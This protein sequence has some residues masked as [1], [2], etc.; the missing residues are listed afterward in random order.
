M[1][2]KKKKKKDGKKERK[3][4]KKRKEK[5]KKKKKETQRSRSKV[6]RELTFGSRYVF[7]DLGFLGYSSKKQLKS[8]VGRSGIRD[9]SLSNIVLLLSRLI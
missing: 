1:K 4:E 9:L 2:K 5:K 7:P 3:K 8:H 6:E